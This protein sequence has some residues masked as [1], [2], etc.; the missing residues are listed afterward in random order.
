MQTCQKCDD[1]GVRGVVGIRGRSIFGDKA[2]CDCER[3]IQ[4]AKTVFP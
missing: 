1:I 3:S 4:V 2:P